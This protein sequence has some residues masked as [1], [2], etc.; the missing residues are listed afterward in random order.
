[1]TN[2]VVRLQNQWFILARSEELREQPLE[3]MLHGVPMVLFRDG[4]GRASA[5][6]DRCPHRNVPLSLGQVKHGQL[7]CPY[8]GWR[9]DSEGE[10]KHIPSLIGD[11]AAKARNATAHAVKECDGFVWVY[12]TPGVVP[13]K[14]PYRFALANDRSYT[15]VHQTV[16]AEASLY[17]TTENALDVPHTAFLHK[18]LFRSES[19]NLTITAVV[20]RGADRVEAEYLGETRPPGIVGKL[21]SP[22]GGM[23]THFDRFILP[24]VSEVEYRIGTENHVLVATAMTPVEDF[25]T[26]LYALVAI[27]TRVPLQ[28][29]RPVIEP[30]AM[31]IF[32]QDARILK[33]QTENIQRFGGEQFASTDIDVLGKHIWRLLR[34]AERGETLRDEL[35]EEEKRVQL[36]L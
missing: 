6:A 29:L 26:K 34:A 2:K 11:C 5:L 31:R 27:R 22:S 16:E 3:R 7:E 30:L 28:V 35:T 23:V 12:S 25:R 36:V 32:A 33:R 20:R 1:M 4:S 9:F 17:S 19:R 10:C 24:C 15:H 18:G 8:H 13:D 21:L 14:E